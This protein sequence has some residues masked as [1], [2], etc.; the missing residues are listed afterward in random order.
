VPR[1]TGG[2]QMTVYVDFSFIGTQTASCQIVVYDRD[3]SPLTAKTVTKTGSG[4][5]RGSATFSSLENPSWAY[6]SANCFLAN[7][8]QRILGITAAY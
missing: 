5:Q 6:T 4:W 2:I 3:N 7:P 8:S 1:E